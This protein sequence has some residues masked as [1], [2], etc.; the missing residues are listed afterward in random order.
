[1]TEE[2]TTAD[3]IA[4]YDGYFGGEYDLPVERL[5]QGSRLRTLAALTGHQASGR[6]LVVGCGSGDDLLV[7]QAE[8]LVA[9][10]LSSVAV[11]MARDH[12]ST[13]QYLQA[14]GTQLPFAT[15][16]FDALLCS[17]VIEHVLEPGS[18]VSEFARVLKPDGSLFLST[19][20]WISWW[21]LARKLAEWALRRP[22]TSGGQPVDNWFTPR[23]LRRTLA[24][25][26]DIATWRGVWYF[27]PTGIGLRRLPD[28]LVAPVFRLLMPLDRLWGRLLPRLGHLHAVRAVRRA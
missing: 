8:T 13:A 2:R 22:V 7:L 16:T 14:D 9:S 17:E 19:P 25:H 12:H 21:G 20:N 11:R 15:G 23:R 24:E 10:D 18:L 26:F 28:K 1:V 3:Q 5:K 27:P 6:A 4:F